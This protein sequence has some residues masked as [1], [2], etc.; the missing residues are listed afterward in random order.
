L[1]ASSGLIKKYALPQFAALGPHCRILRELY[2]SP[3][4]KLIR[5]IRRL[6]YTVAALAALGPWP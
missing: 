6:Q 5:Q 2:G 1:P 4:I 3:R